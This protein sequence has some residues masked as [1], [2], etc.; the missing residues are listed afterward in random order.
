M[1]R[2]EARDVI[3]VFSVGGGSVERNVSPHLVVALDYAKSVGASVLGI[4]GRDGGYAAK[5][6]DVCVIIPTV[7]PERVTPTLRH[8]KRSSGTCGVASSAATQNDQVGSIAPTR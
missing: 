8:S 6:A 7:H 4:V 1:S 2:L 3:L 5:L